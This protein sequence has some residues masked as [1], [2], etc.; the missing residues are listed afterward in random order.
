MLQCCVRL[1]SSVCK[2]CVLEQK[3]L[4]TAYRMSYIDWYQNEWPWP[5]FR[6]VLR[7]CQTLRHIRHWISRKLLEIEV[8]FQRTTNRKW[9]IGNRMATWPTTSHDHERSRSSRDPDTLKAQYFENS[10]KCYLATIANYY[11][12]CCE[13]VRSTILATTWLLAYPL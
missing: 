2:Q 11:I 7:S 3:L 1:S 9:P 10:W 5:L 8:W 13:A 4:L 12:V 6:G